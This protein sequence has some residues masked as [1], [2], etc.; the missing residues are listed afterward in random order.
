VTSEIEK[1]IWGVK[2]MVNLAGDF[3]QH[4]L[5]IQGYKPPSFSLPSLII[6]FYLIQVTNYPFSKWK[7]YTTTTLTTYVLLV[8]LDF[9]HISR[10]SFLRVC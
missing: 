3:L 8:Q 10:T 9:L 6:I 5:I 1:S 2:R 7:T 4:Y